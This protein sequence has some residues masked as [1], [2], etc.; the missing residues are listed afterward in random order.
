MGFVRFVNLAFASL[1]GIALLVV[2]LAAGTAGWVLYRS[3]PPP[4]GNDRLPG[5]AAEVTV[6]HGPHAVPQ[7]FA[8]SL[9]DGYRALGYLHARDRFFQIDFARRIVARRMSAFVPVN[10][11]KRS[12]RLFRTL[13]L[14]RAAEAAAD[15]ALPAT[16]QV[17]DA[18]AEGVNAWLASPTYVRAPELTLAGFDAEPWRPADS[19][20][21]GRLMTWILSTN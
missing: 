12:D 21:I 9:A 5:L 2:V 14:Y 18:Y 8:G 7:I 11:S 3:V 6:I 20:A 13:G 4:G 1:T 17:L 10:A 15:A 19:L 16:Q